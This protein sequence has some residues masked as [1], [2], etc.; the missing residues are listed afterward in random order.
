M[1]ALV[2]RLSDECDHS[3]NTISVS[4]RFKANLCS[5]IFIKGWGRGGGGRGAL[6]VG[7]RP[8]APSGSAILT[9]IECAILESSIHVYIIFEHFC[10][11]YKN[12]VTNETT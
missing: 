8:Q 7:V 9:I 5:D 12:F 11:K 4:R 10:W 3:V 2:F 6:G 1:L